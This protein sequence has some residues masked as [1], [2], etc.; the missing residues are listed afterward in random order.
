LFNR[1]FEFVRLP[2][3]TYDNRGNPVFDGWK[4]ARMVRGTVQPL[5][6]KETVPAIALSRNTGT[7]KVY[8]SER[9]DFR[10]EDGT[11]LG[12]VRCAGHIY[13]LV[14]ELP[15]QNGLINHWKYIGCLVPPSQDNITSMTFRI[16]TN[17]CESIVTNDGDRIVGRI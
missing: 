5:N 10:S 6:G 1:S 9:L 14:D 3:P 8:S 2:K 17:A 16:V 4:E 7:V 11:G 13:E 15:N 12:F